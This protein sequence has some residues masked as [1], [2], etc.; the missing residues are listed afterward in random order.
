MQSK[1]FD[2]TTITTNLNEL[3]KKGKL[4]GAW[5]RK[6]EIQK[7]TQ[8]LLRRTKRNPI[9]VGN[10]GVGKTA[11][12]E[13]LANNIVEKK[14]H[15]EL[16]DYEIL[17]LDATSLIAGTQTRGSYEESA[18]EL[19]KYLEEN[20]KN[21]LM[22]DEIHNIMKHN[23]NSIQNTISIGEIMKPALSRGSVSCIGITT[24]D[25]YV[26][27]FEKDSAL[28]RRFIPIYIE[29][30]DYEK[31][32]E[33]LINTK[34]YYEE[35][36]KCYFDVKS[37][38]KIMEISSRYIP[39]RK[40]PDKALDLIDEIGSNNM[41]KKR[42]NY[43]ITDKDV[44]EFVSKYLDIPVSELKESNLKKIQNI[45]KKIKNKIVG[46]DEVIDRILR[47]LCRAECNIRDKKR[48]IASFL[49]YGASG[50]GKTEIVKL[51]SENYGY[52]MIRIDMSEYMSEISISGM[53]GTPPGYIGYEEGGIL[54][55]KIKENPYS[56]ILFD[57]IEK[58]HPQVYNLLLQIM[59]DGVIH[60]G[61]GKKYY[62]NNSIIF[63]TSNIDGKEERTIGFQEIE[64]KKEVKKEK[65][66]EVFKPEFL[67]RIDEIIK[68]N[69]LKQNEL[70]IIAYKL[71]Y[72][73]IYEIKK[74]MS[75]EEITEYVE[76]IMK[77]SNC[78]RSVERNIDKYI[79]DKYVEDELK[80][81]ID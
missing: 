79:V 51:I 62:F 64:P 14:S 80:S 36:H 45:E 56:V 52:N 68:M 73:K 38:E 58:A 72:G 28:N 53:I 1:T 19:I 31:T 12:I 65:L 40:Y 48:P 57:E 17:E 25:E 71:I 30:P 75:D 24:Y 81:F 60:D 32:K 4:K 16:E 33:I 42:K 78:P 9:I 34:K 10:A 5:G 77:E 37:I 29:E 21:I 11:L 66:L 70:K 63:M 23:N 6:E 50:V 47:C 27:Y 2:I 26:K 61:Q 59:E 3:S 18:S 35:Y 44:I 20:E 49:L 76:K 43:T 41:I 13:E 7:I 22:I 46:Q 55:K 39:Y 54:T 69:H 67:N 8:V 15:Y 74:D